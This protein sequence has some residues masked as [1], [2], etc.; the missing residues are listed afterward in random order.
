MQQEEYTDLRARIDAVA[1]QD[2]HLGRALYAMAAYLPGYSDAEQA[3]LDA[4]AQARAEAEQE[5]AKLAEEPPAEAPAEP[6][7]EQPTPEAQPVEPAPEQPA[8]QAEPFAAPVEE[9]PA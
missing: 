9:S 1:V 5:Q 3:R 8:P 6:T 4:D 7:P 2:V